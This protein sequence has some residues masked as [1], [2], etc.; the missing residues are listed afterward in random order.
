MKFRLAWYE[1]LSPKRRQQVNMVAAGLGLGTVA[2]LVSGMIGGGEGPRVAPSELPKPKSIGAVPGAQLDPKDAWMGGAGKDLAA[3]RDTVSQQNVAMEAL[4]AELAQQRAMHRAEVSQLQER[5]GTLNQTVQGGAGA[6]PQAGS[7][8]TAPGSPFALPGAGAPPG[9]AAGLPAATSPTAPG[10]G[11]AGALNPR[12]INAPQSLPPAGRAPAG[13]A[14]GS[15]AA[16]GPGFPPGTPNGAAGAAATGVVGFGE[17]AAPPP[18][19]M[20]KVNVAA[21]GAP[22]TGATSEAAAGPDGAASA[23]RP[24]GPANAGAGKA[25]AKHVNSYLPVSYTRAVLLGGLAAPTGGQAQS[26]P[27]PVLLR[28]ADLAV[29]PNG[30]R[31]QVKDCLVVAE[32]WG[33]Q[34]AERA[35]IRTVLL[36]CVLLDGRVVEVPI[37]GSIFGEDGMNGINGTLVTKQGAILT[38]ALLA[39]IASGI[40]SGITAAS[41]TVSTSPLGS[42]QVPSSDATS[43]L[44]QGLGTGVGRALD[45]LSQYYISLAEKTFPVIE[46]RPGRFVNMALNQGVALGAAIAAAAPNGA[47]VAPVAQMAPVRGT[48]PDTDRSALMRV[49]S[50]AASGDDE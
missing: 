42:V 4:R 26:N 38:N 18:P 9:A 3:L 17:V 49:T 25:S 27:V 39:G 36:S 23:P 35:Y 14:P 43:I 50:A 32:G 12:P 46:V 45:R 5:L 34:S 6:Q 8:S 21:P 30:F 29:L 24:S 15:P 13:V 20:V 44:K 40:G 31:S 48:T 22:G 2:L 16:A 10:A 37:K 7:P 11:G 47:L 19:V 1:Q 28:L 33:D 41:T